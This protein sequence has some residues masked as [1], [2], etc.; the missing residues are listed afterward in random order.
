[1]HI[2]IKWKFGLHSDTTYERREEEKL[3]LWRTT[4]KSG[5]KSL[6]PDIF[7]SLTD[8][9]ATPH[10]RLC[11]R[12]VMSRWMKLFLIKQ[13]TTCR[14]CLNRARRRWRWLAR[15]F[16]QGRRLAIGKQ[17]M[18]INALEQKLATAGKRDE[19][20]E[21]NLMKNPHNKRA[22]CDSNTLN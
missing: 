9:T 19:W 5:S 11:A 16:R 4:A 12:Q 20:G 1:M 18:V 13:K 21:N 3:L 17:F 8:A 2:N 14:Q 10:H 15:E 7:H 6:R 22:N